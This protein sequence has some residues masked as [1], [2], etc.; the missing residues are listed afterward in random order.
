MDIRALCGQN[1]KRAKGP[2]TV[3]D[4]AGDPLR[5]FL[6]LHRRLEIFEGT[7]PF[8]IADIYKKAAMAKE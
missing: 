7:V 3:R 4:D 6:L 1:K 8:P 2:G 5:A